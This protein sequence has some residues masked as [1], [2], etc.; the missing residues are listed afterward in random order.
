MG[1]DREVVTQNRIRTS[2]VLVFLGLAVA[3][4]TLLWESPVAFLVFLAAGGLLVAAGIVRYLLALLA[5]G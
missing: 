3:G 2:A 1:T 4:L 5:R